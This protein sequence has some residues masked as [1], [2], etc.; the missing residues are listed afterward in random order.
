MKSFLPS[1]KT[2]VWGLILG[3]TAIALYNNF[4]FVQKIAGSKT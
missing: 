3:I 4:A 2:I 1:T